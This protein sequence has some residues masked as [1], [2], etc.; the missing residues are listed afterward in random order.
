M[1]MMYEPKPIEDTARAPAPPVTVKSDA[2]GAG[3]GFAKA[4]TGHPVTL[5]V[6]EVDPPC[7][8]ETTVAVLMSAA[9]AGELPVRLPPMASSATAP[10]ETIFLSVFELV[11]GSIKPRPDIRPV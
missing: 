6:T 8:A 2:S 7:G 1:M 10:S 4:F 11:I 5:S 3:V 9:I